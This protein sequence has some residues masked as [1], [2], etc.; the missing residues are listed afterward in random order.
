MHALI[1]GATGFIG[2]H[3]CARLLSE[4]HQVTA[5][6]RDPVVA[7]RR[8]PGAKAVQADLN[9]MTDPW[10]WRPLLA[11]VDAVVN[12]A[13]ILQS[14]HGQSADVIHTR[15]PNAL[16]D[17]C[18]AEGVG[19]VVQISAVSADPAVGTAYAITKA[20]ADAHLRTLNLDWIVLRPSL[21][22]G[23]GSH[24][25]TSFLRGLAGL[26]GIVPLIGDGG[27]VFQPIHVDDLADAVSRCLSPSFPPRQTLDPVGPE[28]MTLRSMVEMTRNWLDIP[29]ARYLPVPLPLIRIVAR[30]G[31]LVG[32]GP[33][34]STAL[35]QLEYGNVA[36]PG[37]FSAAIGFRPRSMTEAFQAAP[38]HVQDRWHARLYFIPP[39]LTLVLA[40]LWIG[41]GLAGLTN[42]PTDALTV[43]MAI[44][45]PTEAVPWIVGLFC[46]IDIGIGLR[47]AT[48]R[49]GRWCGWLQ[50]VMV[51]GYTLGMTLFI[52][53]LWYDP[54][55]ALL[56]NLPTLC[57]ILVWLAMLDDR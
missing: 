48:G 7:A 18:V 19:R 28:T 54:Y 35:A 56:K 44:G 55:G 43:T 17:A 52:P 30:L 11:G 25:G 21:V 51:V 47:L 32:A 38:S 22:Y 57:A 16:F 46:L 20:A 27:Q 23:P 14:R 42:P 13:G 9:R 6:V 36:D 8:F 5:V 12:C 3:I 49:A 15:A 45:A 1:T 33:V 40:L 53:S 50:V 26:P 31:D 10:D 24:G 2:R 4:G 29:P 39:L 37:R 41:S 34:T